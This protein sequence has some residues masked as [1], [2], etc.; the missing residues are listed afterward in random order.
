MIIQLDAAQVIDLIDDS[1]SE[2]RRLLSHHTIAIS[3]SIVVDLRNK[4]DQSSEKYYKAFRSLNVLWALDG[5]IVC[6]LEARHGIRKLKNGLA[7]NSQFDKG[8]VFREKIMEAFAESYSIR[9]GISIEN[10][11]QIP[12]W[13]KIVEQSFG[14]FLGNGLNRD[15]WNQNC[16]SFGEKVL[17]QWTHYIPA[18]LADEPLTLREILSNHVKREGDSFDFNGLGLSEK[19]LSNLFPANALM[20]ALHRINFDDGKKKWT[21]NDVVDL[22]NVS[23]A[24]YSDCSF[25]DAR[26]AGKVCRAQKALGLKTTVIPNAEA[27]NFLK[28]NQAGL[29]DSPSSQKP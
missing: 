1:D 11:R 8:F 18:A 2:L 10:L 26:T 17:D 24:P 16:D 14:D 25:M 7:T 15:M 27:I 20:M 12:G 3:T 6:V 19:E 29:N 21:K 28:A 22:W 5:G 9:N 13:D 23:L 4:T